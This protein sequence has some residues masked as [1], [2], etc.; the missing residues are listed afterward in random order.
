MKKSRKQLEALAAERGVAIEIELGARA[1]SYDDS[2][3]EIHAE[4]PAGK[5]DSCNLHYR[6]VYW[7]PSEENT[8]EIYGEI[9]E[10][11]TTLEDC[12]TADC[13]VCAEG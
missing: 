4:Y 10:S 1:N 7:H 12:T 6:D 9:W 5:V 13:E 8:Y 3:N 11:I 2:P